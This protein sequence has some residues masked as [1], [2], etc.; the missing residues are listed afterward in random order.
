MRSTIIVLDGKY[1][2]PDQ[3]SQ[4]EAFERLNRRRVQVGLEEV[5]TEGEL[6]RVVEQTE[7]PPDEE[8]PIVIS[9]PTSDKNAAKNGYRNRDGLLRGE[10]YLYYGKSKNAQKSERKKHTAAQ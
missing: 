9:R 5:F 2:Y 3:D 10:S 8:E 4:A 6:L 7:L 1:V